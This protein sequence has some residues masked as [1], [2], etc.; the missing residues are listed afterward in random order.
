[1][2]TGLPLAV[3][4]QSLCGIAVVALCALLQPAWAEQAVLDAPEDDPEERLEAILPAPEVW[5][6]DFD[7]IRERR[8]L[9]ILVPYSKTFFFIDRGTQRG[10]D[11]DFGLAQARTTYGIIGV[12]VW[13][14]KGEVLQR[15]ARRIL[16]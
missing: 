15:K 3:L 13:I 12:K 2:A 16:Q 8:Q 6:G 14:F 1:M 7:G 11:V 5:I 9:R 10:T 4:R